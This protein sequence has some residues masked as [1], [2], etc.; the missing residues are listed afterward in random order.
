MFFALLRKKPV[1]LISPSNSAGSASAK[2]AA[3]R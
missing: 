2:S 1:D 3:V